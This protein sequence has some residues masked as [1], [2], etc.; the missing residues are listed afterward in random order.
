MRSHAR[1]AVQDE[2]SHAFVTTILFSPS[3]IAQLA[4]VVDRLMRGRDVALMPAF[5]LASLADNW[6]RRAA[7]VRRDCA[8]VG[9]VYGKE[10]TL[11]G[12]P[13]GL[14]CADERLGRPAVA[15]REDA[16]AVITAGVRAWVVL[17]IT[18]DVRWMVGPGRSPELHT[19]DS[20]E[21]SPARGEAACAR[22]DRSADVII[23]VS[24]RP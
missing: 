5:V 3:A 18:A 8:I 4:R 11:T 7:V 14:V 20:D 6:L 12:F 9:I 2:A 15:A 16:E 21:P 17:P 24:P 1:A 13:T 23:G 10:R 19:V 22:T